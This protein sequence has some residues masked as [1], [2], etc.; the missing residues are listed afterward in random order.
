MQKQH[1]GVTTDGATTGGV[2]KHGVT[3]DVV[4]APVKILKVT[5]AS[6]QTSMLHLQLSAG[7]AQVTLVTRQK[8]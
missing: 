2:T 1:D 6:G 3:N 4:T 5:F 7:N 8:G